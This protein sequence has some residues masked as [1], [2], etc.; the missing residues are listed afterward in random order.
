[1]KSLVNIGIAWTFGVCGARLSVFHFRREKGR[2]A[3]PVATA[4][5][6]DLHP[7]IKVLLCTLHCCNQSTVRS[8]INGWNCSSSHCS[9]GHSST[10]E[11]LIAPA[12]WFS[13]EWVSRAQPCVRGVSRGAQRRCLLWTDVLAPTRTGIGQS[14]TYSIPVLRPKAPSSALRDVILLA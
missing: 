4:R 6:F 12:V 8:Q 14:V 9:L 3:V 7:Q 1:M 11:F 5:S 13:V 10:S 2:A